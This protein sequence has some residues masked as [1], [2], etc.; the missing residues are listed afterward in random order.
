M[1]NLPYFHGAKT[2]KFKCFEQYI[3]GLLLTSWEFLVVLAS[4][5]AYEPKSTDDD[6]DI[7]GEED[8]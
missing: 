5:K 2:Y 8:D 4:V 3:E 1:A 6:D 7:G